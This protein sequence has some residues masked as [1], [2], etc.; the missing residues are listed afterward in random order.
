MPRKKLGEVL[1][2]RKVIDQKQ[3]ADAL[4]FARQSG[5][6]LGVAL[7]TR[8]YLSEGMLAKVLSE[9]MN[10][11]AVDLA[12]A[13]FDH[14]AFKL[15]SHDTCKDNDLIPI[16][17]E[18]KR[19]TRTLVLAMAD[20]MNVAV[21]DEIEFTSGC[22]VR[23]VMATLSAIHSAIRKYLLGMNTV[24]VPFSMIP[25]PLKEGVMTIIRPGGEAQE[26]DTNLPKERQRLAQPAPGAAPPPPSQPKGRFDTTG[27]RL[28]PAPPPQAAPARLPSQ[29]PAP[30]VPDTGRR[31]APP[32][33]ADSGSAPKQLTPAEEA[34]R[35][36]L[37]EVQTA[38][39]ET[40]QKLEKI[41]KYFWAL[42]RAMARKGLISKEEFLKEMKE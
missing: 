42:V 40:L 19:G 23:P 7:V 37:K 39:P 22:K 26:V 18:E 21:I 35:D 25:Q 29:P 15:V 6:R 16:A 5:M 32:R 11:P 8:G 31:S 2:E 17:I 30:A 34:L 41:E 27:S 28:K 13:P 3:L 33:P 4:A 10:L 14:E 38:D 36:Y 24:I 12:T 1:V 20:P 9:E